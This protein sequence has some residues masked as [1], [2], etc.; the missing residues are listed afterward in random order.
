MLLPKSECW[1][2]IYYILRLGKHRREAYIFNH[3]VST[4]FSG[5]YQG[6]RLHSSRMRTAHSLTVSPSMLCS[7]GGLV[8]GGCLVLG[9]SAPGGGLLLGGCLVR[10]E[11]GLFL[12]QPGPGGRWCPRGR[13][14]QWTEWQTGVKILP[15]PK[16]RLQAEIK[17]RFFP[18]EVKISGLL[19][20]YP[21][22]MLQCIKNNAAHKWVVPF[23]EL[24]PSANSVEF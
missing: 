24:E 4:L 22:E 23:F 3:S 16:L 11:G 7:R 9:G 20:L 12:G 18:A 10:G 5:F 14:P 8:R 17:N 1:D 15:C 13:P 19:L 21:W 2:L 6:T